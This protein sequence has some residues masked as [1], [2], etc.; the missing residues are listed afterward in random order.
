MAL[1]FTL[2]YDRLTE[3][4]IGYALND[5]L[6]IGFNSLAEAYPEIR[7]ETYLAG[8]GPARIELSTRISYLDWDDPE[9]EVVMPETDGLTD[10]TDDY[11]ALNRPY[12]S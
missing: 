12:P 11:P 5:T 7:P 2:R 9:V 4:G 8:L 6:E 3:F 1:E 10:V